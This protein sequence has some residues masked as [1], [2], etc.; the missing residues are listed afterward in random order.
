M[1]MMMLM[2]MMMMMMTM[3]MM[4]LMMMMMI[5]F[6][7]LQTKLN[8]LVQPI[9][10]PTHAALANGAVATVTLAFQVASPTRATTA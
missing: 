5:M 9:D 1:M 6:D 10:G 4:T 8:A 3:M 2:M 7:T